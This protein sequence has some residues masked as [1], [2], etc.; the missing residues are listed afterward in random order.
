MALILR[1]NVVGPELSGFWQGLIV[2]IEDAGGRKI[3]NM[4]TAIGIEKRQQL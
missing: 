2:A 3:Q 1:A 4:L